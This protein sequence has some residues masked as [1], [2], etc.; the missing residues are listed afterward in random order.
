[1]PAPADLLCVRLARHP[2]PIRQ[3]CLPLQRENA[4]KKLRRLK[5]RRDFVQRLLR[6]AENHA[7][8]LLEKEWVLHAGKAER[9]LRA[10]FR[11]D[12]F[13]ESDVPGFR[14]ARKC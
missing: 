1:M 11:S 9:S 5:L 12:I 6:G 4:R 10:N 8:V 2:F 3:C 13:P 7:R 14:A